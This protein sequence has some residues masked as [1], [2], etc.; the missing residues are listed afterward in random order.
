VVFS[1]SHVW[2]ERDCTIATAGGEETVD[3]RPRNEL[4][5]FSRE[6]EQVVPSNVNTL[7]AESMSWSFRRPLRPAVTPLGAI[8]SG[9]TSAVSHVLQ[10]FNPLFP[11]GLYYGYIDSTGSPN[12][13]VIHPRTQSY[14]LADRFRSRNALLVWRTSAADGIFSRP[15]FFLRSGNDKN[16]VTSAV[17]RTSP[18]GGVRTATRP[19]RRLPPLRGRRVPARKLTATEKLVGLK[20]NYRF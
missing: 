2:A 1:K 5:A 8:S 18:S 9:N 16:P 19:S 15:G 13:T 12:A 4:F 14:C 20:M 17:F 10:T 6:C 11:R 3:L 7:V